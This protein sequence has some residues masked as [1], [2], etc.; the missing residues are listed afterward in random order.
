MRLLTTKQGLEGRRREGGI[1][2]AFLTAFN[3]RVGDERG[4]DDDDEGGGRKR[5]G[6]QVS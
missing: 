3:E 5:D 4:D 6:D 1:I 2:G